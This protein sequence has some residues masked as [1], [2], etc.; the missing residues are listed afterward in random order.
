MVAVQKDF[1]ENEFHFGK[2]ARDSTPEDRK[3]G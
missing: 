3:N 1:L 2:T